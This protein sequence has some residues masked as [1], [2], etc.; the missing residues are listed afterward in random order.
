MFAVD[1][2]DEEQ[3]KEYMENLHTEYMFSCHH[4]KNS[5]G[6]VL[7]G[8]FYTN[9]RKEYEKG[10]EVYKT[11]CNEQDNPEACYKLGKA[12]LAGKGTEVDKDEAYRCFKKGCDAGH[13]G[14]CHNMGLLYSAG[15]KNG[16][17]EPELEKAI[18]CFKSACNKD[19][20][21]SCFMLSGLYL[22]GSKTVPK[23]M[24]KALDYSVKSCDLGLLF[25]CVNATRMYT[26][27]DGVPKNPEL[28][29]KYKEIAKEMHKQIK[30]QQK[31]M[32][33]SV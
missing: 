27:G 31:A 33:F 16:G 9:I 8:D 7:L 28:A 10:V 32:E 13:S 21:Q 26:V 11:A 6:C 1:F 20:V 12:C 18:E 29:A 30:E 25:G 3:V 19:Y 14:A 23:D 5:D 24:K 17:K 15:K 4:E 2:K 22:R